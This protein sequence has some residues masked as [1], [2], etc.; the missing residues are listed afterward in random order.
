[1]T[2]SSKTPSEADAV[3]LD[4]LSGFYWFDEGLQNFMLARGWPEVSRPQS[5]VMANI[6]MGNAYPSEIARKLGVSRQAVHVTLKSM[7][8]KDMI[9]LVDDPTNRRVKIVKLTP[10]GED[11]RKDAKEA[12]D[13]IMDRLVTRIG[14]SAF[15]NMTSAL[16]ADW[17]QPLQFGSDGEAQD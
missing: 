12:M 11:M 15:K 3:M 2:D 13:L 17:G 9:A 1:M 14:R 4:L 16:S 5:M 7:I 10:T 6:I 8:D